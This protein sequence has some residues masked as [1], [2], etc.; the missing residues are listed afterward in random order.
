LIS[1]NSLFALVLLAGLL[2]GCSSSPKAS[3]YTLSADAALQHTGAAVPIHIVVSPVTV[4]D[5]V[6]RPQIVTRRTTG[7]EVELE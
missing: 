7:N 6:D 5:L 2:G 4:P 3:F 1:T